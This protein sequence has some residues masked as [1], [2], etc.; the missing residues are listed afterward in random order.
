MGWG[1]RDLEFFL[2]IDSKLSI[3]WNKQETHKWTKVCWFKSQQLTLCYTKL[4]Y[5][6]HNKYSILSHCIRYL[7]EFEKGILS[8][9]HTFTLAEFCV[10]CTNVDT[11]WFT[12]K[13]VFRLP[14]SWHL[15]WICKFSDISRNQRVLL[16][17]T[18]I[19]GSTRSTTRR[20]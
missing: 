2:S 12:I 10:S 13:A 15:C 16:A 14:S 3:F 11:A 20:Y 9:N 18:W 1:L 17:D 19:Q 8:I 6:T 5:Y 4:L 7:L